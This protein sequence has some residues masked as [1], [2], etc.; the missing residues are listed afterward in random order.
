MSE[1]IVSISTAELSATTG[2]NQ[3]GKLREVAEKTR[4][5]SF[6]QLQDQ[7]TVLYATRSFT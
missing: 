2:S 3:T 7:K 6:V 1:D 4:D 5:N